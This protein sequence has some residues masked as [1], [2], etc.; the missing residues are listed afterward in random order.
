MATTIITKYGNGKPGTD[1]LRHGELAIDMTGSILYTKD[2]NDNIIQL[3]GGT[4]GWDQIDPDTIPPEL[5]AIIDGTVDLDALLE[6]ANQNEI[7]IGNLGNDLAELEKRVK[8]NE[9]AILALQNSVGDLDDQ[10][11]GDG[12][13]LERL[14]DAEDDIKDNATQIGINTGNISSNKQEIDA[15]KLLVEGGVTGL[16]LGGEYNA[17]NNVV[18]NPTD[19]GRDVG[20]VHNQPLPAT[21]GTKGFYVI[22]TTE[23]VL[24]GTGISKANGKSDGET[25]YPG[26]WLISDGVHGWVLFEF[27]TDAT[28]WGQIGGDITNQDDL[29]EALELKFDKDGG[30]LECGRY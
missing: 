16:T 27:H 29:Q 15:L 12:G 19:E 25:A 8:A 3:G 7:D 6:L 23:G 18:E 5:I 17:A 2:G 13:I 21:A 1:D 9:S 24:S 22:V 4:V 14:G 10:I 20:L 28:V 11:N 30:T 26:D